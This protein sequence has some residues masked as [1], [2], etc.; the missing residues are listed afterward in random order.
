MVQMKSKYEVQ[1]F[2]T[3]EVEELLY[4]FAIWKNSIDI[5]IYS[6]TY[7]NYDSHHEMTVVYKF[8]N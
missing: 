1:V 3:T 8:K 6:L 5:S 2:R 7:N 4:I